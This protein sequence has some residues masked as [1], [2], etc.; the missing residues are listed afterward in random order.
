MDLSTLNEEHK[1][2]NRELYVRVRDLVKKAF[3]LLNEKLELGEKPFLRRVEDISVDAN[4]KLLVPPLGWRDYHV[5][6]DLS[7]FIFKYGDELSKLPEWKAVL[8]SLS[9]DDTIHKHLRHEIKSPFRDPFFPN[10]YNLLSRIIWMSVDENNPFNFNSE[11]FDFM[12]NEVE[13]YFYSKTVV[14]NSFC[15]LLGFDSEVQEI[16]LGHGLRIRNVSEDEI[17]ELWHRVNWFRGLVELSSILRF[18]PL[19]YVLELSIEA[20]KIAKDERI[21]PKFADPEFQK[22]LSALRLFK[23][24]WVGY[25]FIWEGVVSNLSTV[26]TYSLKHSK[27]LFSVGQPVGISYNLSKVE[28]EDFRE[29]FKKISKKIDHSRISLKRFNET[30]QRIDVED[31]L[32]DYII[33]LES[34]YAVGGGEKLAHRASFL[35]GK[36]GAKKERIFLELFKAWKIRNKIVHGGHH[37][38]LIEIP[39]LNEKHTLDEF[40]QKIEA[41]SRSSIRL[42]LE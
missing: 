23:K 22:V 31:K 19:K 34:L 41:Y 5:K 21:E 1:V 3:L 2:R 32:I 6:P 35:L 36:R 30:Y 7:G 13:S 12:Y 11:I 37:P 40:V 33:S 38:K 42:F 9:R 28:A 4:G 18:T 24:G 17:L 15:L 8:K 10:E 29:Y 25:P 39:E 14:R 27:A 16:E 26:I 20:P